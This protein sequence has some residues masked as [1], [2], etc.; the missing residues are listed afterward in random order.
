MLLKFWSRIN[1]N[2]HSTN[3]RVLSTG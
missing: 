2:Q 3:H 1:P